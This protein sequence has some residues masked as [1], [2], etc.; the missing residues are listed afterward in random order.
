MLTRV[1][2]KRSIKRAQERRRNKLPYWR[3]VVVA[4]VTKRMR[5]VLFVLSTG[6]GNYGLPK[7]G[8]ENK[9]CGRVLE[10]VKRE[11]SEEV[12]LSQSDFLTLTYLG[13]SDDGERNEKGG[14]IG[15]RFH[16]VHVRV[17]RKTKP[18]ANL[19]HHVSRVRWVRSLKEF[20]RLRM[21]RHRRPVW[22]AALRKAGVPWAEPQE[23]KG[24]RAA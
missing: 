3:P 7:G 5:Q 20:D 23:N 22:L 17:R 13:S 10:A 1:D 11:L 16:F 4:V 18:V 8:I 14:Q 15:Q 9:D 2:T 19:A 24:R 12:S 21:R 6:T